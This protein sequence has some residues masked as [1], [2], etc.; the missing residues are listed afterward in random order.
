MGEAPP[1]ACDGSGGIPP[2]AGSPARLAAG[3]AA[4]RIAIERGELWLADSFL[5]AAEADRLL[6]RLLER[7]PWRQ[8]RIHMFGRE[9]LSPRLAAWYGDPG[10]CY[11]YSGLRNEPLPWLEELAELRE[12]LE[13][14]TGAAFNSVLL[15]LYR[16]GG[17][18]M[19]WHSDDEKELG[20]NPVIA[21]LSL[22]VAR[23]FRL[24]PKKGRR[25]PGVDLDL[26]RGSLL[27]MAGE[28][29]HHWRHAVPKSAA[30]AGP[31]INLTYRLV[32]GPQGRD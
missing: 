28:T 25:A 27:V 21:S 22:G 31:R 6:D 2:G 8:P 23:R 13:A 14:F 29:Q 4:R 15:N 10:A 18:S 7:V 1:P 26:G 11:T 20:P 30:A 19:G 17:D 12:R 32:R 5:P 3:S 9:I 16:D 24:R